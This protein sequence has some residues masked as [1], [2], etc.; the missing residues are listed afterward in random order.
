MEGAINCWPGGCS[1]VVV[2]CACWQLATLGIWMTGTA[3]NV[4]KSKLDKYLLVFFE[5]SGAAACLD[6]SARVG[7]DVNGNCNRLGCV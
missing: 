7:N 4:E 1:D 3:E 6:D 5:I 2:V